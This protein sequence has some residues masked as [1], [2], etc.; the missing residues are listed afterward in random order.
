MPAEIKYAVGL[1]MLDIQAE[2]RPFV[3]SESAGPS[4]F[5][6]PMLYLERAFAWRSAA[7]ASD[8]FNETFTKIVRW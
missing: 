6:D 2:R 4:A 1:S 3:P 7:S 5:M 8:N